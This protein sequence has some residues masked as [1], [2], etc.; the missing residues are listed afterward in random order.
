MGR[1]T[2]VRELA[3]RVSIERCAY[4]A[5]E[6]ISHKLRTLVRQD[7]R[8]SGEAE[9]CARSED[10]LYQAGGTIIVAERNDPSL[11]VSRGALVRL[12][13]ACDDRDLPPSVLGKPQGRGRASDA[14]SDNEYVAL[15]S[16]HSYSSSIR[17]SASRADSAT[18]GGTVTAFV[19]APWTSP[20]IT[21]ASFLTVM[22]F[23]V[24]QRLGR[25]DRE[26]IN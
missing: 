22:R 12:R 18:F 16:V 17:L 24:P 6:N 2:S 8:R 7:A 20:S 25:G 9:P 4:C 26:S 11:R 5:D 15:D 23:I 19:T 13:R 3:I 1:L 10:V 21:C 14:A